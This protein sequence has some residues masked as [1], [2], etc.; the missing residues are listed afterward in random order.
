METIKE[1]RI[2][3]CLTQEEFMIKINMKSRSNYSKIE[4]RKHIPSLKTKRAIARVFD[5]NPS[6][7]DW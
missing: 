3:A 2:K 5:I 7:I 1:L 4:N 6:E